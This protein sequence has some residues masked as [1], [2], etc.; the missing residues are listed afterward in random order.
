MAKHRPSLEAFAQS[1][2]PE[3]AQVTISDE[4]ASLKAVE[5][6][7]PAAVASVRKDRPHTTLYLSKKVQRVIKEI[8]FQY[9]RKPH[10][11]YL[12]GINLML[13]QYGRPSIDDI[14]K[15]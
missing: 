4:M 15:D 13:T 10:D 5:L 14:S 7:Q 2:T 9:D 12:E 11:L 6:V 8:A 1:G 3:P